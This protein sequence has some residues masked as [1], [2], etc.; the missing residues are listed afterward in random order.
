MNEKIPV[1]S[2]VKLRK[3]DRKGVSGDYMEFELPREIES[4]DFSDDDEQS[5][6][7]LMESYT[8]E[9]GDNNL[10]VK[11]S[12]DKP[13]HLIYDLSDNGSRHEMNLK[14]RD[15]SDSDGVKYFLTLPPEFWR[16]WDSSPLH[17]YRNG[18]EFIV[19]V[20]IPSNRI[21]LFTLM[22]F[23]VRNQQLAKEGLSPKIKQPI[24]FSLP[25][26]RRNGFVD[27]ASRTSYEG[28]KFE[29]IPIDG[30][31]DF[32][33]EK[34]ECIN[35]EVSPVTEF[36][37]LQKWYRLPRT[38][39]HKL[40]IYWD[41][42]FKGINPEKKH[43]LYSEG[44]TRRCRVILPKNGGYIFDVSVG[45]TEFTEDMSFFTDGG[46]KAIYKNYDSVDQD[47]HTLYADQNRG[48]DDPIRLFA[49]APFQEYRLDNMGGSE[50]HRIIWHWD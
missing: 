16:D 49:P 40:T 38:T 21:R 22:D 34:C 39:A 26:V 8:K 12:S 17:G 18:D 46:T 31:H 28:E 1:V 32:W 24:A 3:S 29:I 33:Y 11:R 2:P 45:G 14:I 27:L 42:D 23:R 30:A 9:G 7:G 35:G 50:P 48:E 20:D 25:V 10:F 43:K 6:S 15:K 19:E 13:R 47:W 41:P 5:T 44:W 37:E 36:K 4:L